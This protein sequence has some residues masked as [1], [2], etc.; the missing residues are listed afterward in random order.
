MD[1][2]VEKYWRLSLTHAHAY[3]GIKNPQDLPETYQVLY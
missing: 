2:P 3:V 1:N